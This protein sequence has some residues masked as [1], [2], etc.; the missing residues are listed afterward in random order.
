MGS[1]S[2]QLETHERWMVIAYIKSKQK[3]AGAAAAPVAAADTAA[4]KP[5]TV[6]AAK[7]K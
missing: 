2:A 1:Y 5:A 4:A 3:P 6:I 7:T